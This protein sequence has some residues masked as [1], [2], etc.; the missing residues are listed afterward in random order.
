ME[1]RL[2]SAID[3]TRGR[4]GAWRAGAESLRSKGAV[5]TSHPAGETAASARRE[6][7]P[8]RFL[9]GRPR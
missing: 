6:R 1:L 3:L 8:R 2:E 4:R 7:A 9:S 5:T